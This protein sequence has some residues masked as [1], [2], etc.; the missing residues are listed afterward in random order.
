MIR[1]KKC[2]WLIKNSMNEA[3]KLAMAQA[4]KIDAIAD[5][6]EKGWAFFFWGVLHEDCSGD[7]WN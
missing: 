3:G 5:I 7:K 4:I 1:L 6:T 2:L